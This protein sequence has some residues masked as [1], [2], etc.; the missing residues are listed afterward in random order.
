VGLVDAA[1]E[2]ARGRA[3]RLA[4]LGTGS[5]CIAIALAVRL[6]DAR[7]YALD[8]S[9]AALDLARLNAHA[10]GVAGR[11][12]LCQADLGAPPADWHGAMDV[13]VSNP[14]YVAEADWR[15]LEPEVRDFDPREALVPGP[16]GLEAYAPLARAARLVLRP[17]GALVA[18]L[19][20][21]QAQAV[22]R[23]VAEAGLA[24]DEVRPDLSGIPRVLI[25]LQR[26]AA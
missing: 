2:L 15:G 20:Y 16:T 3:A 4:D 19:G 25:A 23:I 17:G 11:I 9:A 12:E 14:P 1:I 21:G 24:L 6:P 13:V 5:G 10:H 7:L 18:E 8:R 26:G 22:S